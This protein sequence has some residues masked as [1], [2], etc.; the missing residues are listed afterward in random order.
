MIVVQSMT[1]NNC[2]ANP[3]E[4][5]EI[6][7]RKELARFLKLTPLCCELKG[8]IISYT[9][10][11]KFINEFTVNYLTGVSVQLCQYFLDND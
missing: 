3:S 1:F 7:F 8:T 4:E 10:K 9:G 2:G 5:L 6:H 11:S